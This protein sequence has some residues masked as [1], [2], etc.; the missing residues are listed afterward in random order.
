MTAPV[1][2]PPTRRWTPTRILVVVVVVAMLAM[3]VYVVYLAFGPGRQ[4]SPDRLDDPTFAREAQAVCEA[5][6]AEV[7]LLPAAATAKSAADR[8]DIIA[9]ANDRFTAM[10]D[11][12]EPLAP[13][14]EDGEVVA[15]WLADWRSYLGDRVDYVEALRSDPDARLF[16]TARDQSQV[17]EYIDGFAADNHMAACATPLDLG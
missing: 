10:I 13:G 1:A 11:E 6:H 9:E 4:P 14:G 15:Q 12:I 2:D 5:A 16:V 17:T 8:A 7:A 3:W